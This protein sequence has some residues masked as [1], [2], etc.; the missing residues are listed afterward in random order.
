MYQVHIVILC[1]ISFIV[2]LELVDYVFTIYV[3][4]YCYE[5]NIVAG[6]AMVIMYGCKLPLYYK[7]LNG[8]NG[9]ISIYYILLA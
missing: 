3:E 6:G 2:E 5:G 4:L 9:K 8:F 1:G 7:L